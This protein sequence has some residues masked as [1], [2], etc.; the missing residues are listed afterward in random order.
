LRVRPG[1]RD[2]P[3]YELPGMHKSRADT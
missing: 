1:C 2:S 3:A